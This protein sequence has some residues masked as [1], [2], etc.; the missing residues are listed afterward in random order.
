MCSVSPGGSFTSLDMK[1][2]SKVMK[3]ENT[4]PFLLLM[5][6]AETFAEVAQLVLSFSFFYVWS[7]SSWE[8]DKEVVAGSG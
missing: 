2:C 5:D 8:D 4:F 3:Q 7:Q 1:T 6:V